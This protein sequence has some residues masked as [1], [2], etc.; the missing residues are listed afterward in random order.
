[1]VVL[2]AFC[3]ALLTLYDSESI[4]EPGIE[5]VDYMKAMETRLV[6]KMS[7]FEVILYLNLNSLL[8]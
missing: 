4:N 2:I 3:Y 6:K 1:M 7:G 5:S 8:F